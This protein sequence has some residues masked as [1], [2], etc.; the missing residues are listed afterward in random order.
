MQ[1]ITLF[2]KEVLEN[3][4]NFKWVWVPLVIILLAIMDPITNYYL[5][6]LIDI[7]GG[8]PDGAAFEVPVP[9]IEEAIMMSLSQ[10]STLGIL[11]LVLISMGT[12]TSERKSGISELVLAKPVSFRNYIT[13]K[14]VSWIALVWVSL[15][16]GM[17]MIWY[18]GNLLFGEISLVTIALVIFFYGLWLTLVMTLSLFY[19]TLFNSSGVVA[20]FTIATIMVL[21][22][23]TQVFSHILTWSPNKLSEHIHE[24]LLVEEIS[25]D[26]IWTSIITIAVIIILLL[27]SIQLMSKKELAN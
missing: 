25:M 5:P 1:W 12:I 14:W 6:Q 22:L 8:M 21:S 17:A 10:L 26:L 24:M 11:V 16:L 9:S 13:A 27:A 23:V 3:W 19:N 2:Q 18:Y 4:R 7:V 15:I 20:F